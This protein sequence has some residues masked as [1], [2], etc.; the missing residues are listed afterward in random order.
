MLSADGRFLY[1]ANR[2]ADVI[3][4]HEVVGHTLRAVAD[5][6]SGGRQPRHL[7]LRGRHLYAANQASHTVDT[8]VLDESTG[9]PAPTG[10]PLEVGHPSCILL[11]P[12]AV[13]TGRGRLHRVGGCGEQMTRRVKV[14][15][16]GAGW[17]A[18]YVHIP[19]LLDNADAELV[20]VSDRDERRAA[21][22]A[23]R[24]GIG[25]AATD[26]SQLLEL[27]VEAVIV[28]TPHDAHQHPRRPRSTPASTCSS[29]S[30]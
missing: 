4:V 10:V 23:A 30:R 24:F 12:R 29:R 27:G 15:I 3:T 18:N 9:I 7:A 26:V 6:P 5:V 14:G 19:A 22:A 20:G 11:A 8:F 17:W 28:A 21:D 25:V 16:V 2:G 13:P 1:V